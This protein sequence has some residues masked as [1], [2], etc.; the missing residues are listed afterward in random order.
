ME[1]GADFNTGFIADRLSGAVILVIGI[2][3]ILKIAVVYGLDV[4]GAEIIHGSVNGGAE[5]SQSGRLDVFFCLLCQPLVGQS[6]ECKRIISLIITWIVAAALILPAQIIQKLLCRLDAIKSLFCALKL[7]PAFAV[8][9]NRLV[10]IGAEHHGAVGVI[11]EHF[12]AYRTFVI[13]INRPLH[14]HSSLDRVLST[15]FIMVC[16]RAVQ[17]KF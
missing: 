2:Q 13:G 7:H 11:L 3:E 4:L 1:G 6:L 15:V 9:R 12:A 5:I 10:S 16:M 8:M 14:T 17:H